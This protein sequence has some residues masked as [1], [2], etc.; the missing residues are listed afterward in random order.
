MQRLRLHLPGIILFLHFP[1][2]SRFDHSSL[3]TYLVYC[4]VYQ[5]KVSTVLVSN[6][7]GYEWE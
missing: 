3:C 7:P 6:L 1:T 4:F 5:E 2:D